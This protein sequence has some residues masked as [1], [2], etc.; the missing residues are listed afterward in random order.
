MAIRV[1]HA[2]RIYSTYSGFYDLLF[3]RLLQPGRERAVEALDVQP[4]DRILEIG[5][6][7]GLSLPLYPRGCHITGIDVSAGM[8]EQAERRARDMRMRNVSLLKMVAEH[9]SFPDASFD[10]VLAS[11][12]M[13]T[14]SD[15]VR[16]VQ[17]MH[18]VCRMGGRIIIL[19]HLRS[20]YRVIAAFERFLT[21]LSRKIGFVMDLE[22]ST[23]S[24][25]H[26]SMEGIEKV[27]FPPFWSLVSLRKT[28]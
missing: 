10:A 1:E 20:R 17:E 25:G 18:R 21:P 11:Y 27:N 28:S 23:I 6:G 16:V 26:L 7:T 14:V 19:N 3:D 15:P 13:S 8:I 9:M 2:E 22:L 12:V 5:V 24:N 4:G